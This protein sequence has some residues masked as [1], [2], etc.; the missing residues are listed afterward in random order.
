[1]L[2]LITARGGSQGIPRKNIQPVGGKPLIAWTALAARS[3]KALTR[4]ILST[5][6]P[7]IAEV[8]R[9]YGVEVPFMRPAEFA[10][11]ESAH[12]PVVVHALDWLEQHEGYRPEYVVLLQPTSPLRTASDINAATALALTRRAPAVVSVTTAASHP[13]LTY[14]IDA[15][16]RLMPFFQSEI[17][18]KRR[19][20]LPPASALN[21]AIYVIHRD[22]LLRHRTFLPEGTLAYE[23]PPERSLDV[24]SLWDLHLADLLLRDALSHENA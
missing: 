24:D 23:M 7:E 4:T 8:G 18:Y 2:G 11:P 9:Q 14:R 6:S 20:D 1:M 5:D 15:E 13:F 3:A 16:D 21:G 10:G 19:Q 17:A 22:V 12:V